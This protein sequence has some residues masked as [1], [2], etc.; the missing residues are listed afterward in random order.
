LL[1]LK[2]ISKFAINSINFLTNSYSSQVRE[3][4]Y[5]FNLT[6]SECF[7]S[8]SVTGLM[9]NFDSVLISGELPNRFLVIN[10]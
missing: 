5:L 8:N 10:K 3:Y 1:N 9:P 4:E 7:L 2:T 6:E